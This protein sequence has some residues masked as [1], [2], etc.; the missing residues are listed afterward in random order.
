[1]ILLP[2]LGSTQRSLLSAHI[3]GFNF[4]LFDQDK[5]GLGFFRIE[6]PLHKSPRS[7]VLILP[8]RSRGTRLPCE[9]TDPQIVSEKEI[10]AY[11]KWAVFKPASWAKV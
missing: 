11:L 7:G 5:E 10:T 9:L 6:S 3:V 4:I 2:N 8:P 1:M